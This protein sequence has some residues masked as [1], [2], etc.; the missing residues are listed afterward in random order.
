MDVINDSNGD[1]GRNEV[2]RVGRSAGDP[3]LA[4]KI[5]IRGSLPLRREI[6]KVLLNEIDNLKSLFFILLVSDVQ[7]MA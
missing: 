7:L 3:D 4:P 2:Y 5:R 1:F 6:I